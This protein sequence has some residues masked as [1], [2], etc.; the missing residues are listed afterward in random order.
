MS[1]TFHKDQVLYCINPGVVKGVSPSGISTSVVSQVLNPSFPFTARCNFMM[2]RRK[3]QSM[4]IVFKLKLN[5]V[6]LDLIVFLYCRYLLFACCNMCICC[7]LIA[8]MVTFSIKT[9]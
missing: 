4:C 2:R 8:K 1:V 6:G 9:V 5:V 7:Y 3:M